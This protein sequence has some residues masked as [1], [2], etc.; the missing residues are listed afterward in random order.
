MTPNQTLIKLYIDKSKILV[1]CD[2]HFG[3][4]IHCLVEAE[5]II[6]VFGLYNDPL[7]RRD[8]RRAWRKVG[9][10]PDDVEALVEAHRV[11]E[12]GEQKIDIT[13]G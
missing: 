9:G 13:S 11:K 8:M 2:G 7:V 5:S 6:N 4:A 3:R 1:A 12:Q 10:A